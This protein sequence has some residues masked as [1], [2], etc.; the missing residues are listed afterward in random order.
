MPAPSA[1]YPLL[2]R[3]VR[4][5]R[6]HHGWTQEQLAEKAHCDYKYLQLLELG[7]TGSP[8]L[9]LLERVARVLGV[10]PWV[11]LCEDRTLV[12]RLT[13]LEPKAL[14]PRGARRSGRPKSGR[15]YGD[16]IRISEITPFNSVDPPA[17][18]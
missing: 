16:G 8:S 5:L 1:S 15:S 14:A 9:R 13:G 12:L 11:L 7:R 4:A 3:L 10:K 18:R 2:R 6:L 17:I